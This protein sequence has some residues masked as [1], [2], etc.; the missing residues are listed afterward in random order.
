MKFKSK[1]TCLVSI[2]YNRSAHVSVLFDHIGNMF[3]YQQLSPRLWT[4]FKAFTVAMLT[5]Q[6]STEPIWFLTSYPEEIWCCDSGC[7]QTNKS[8]E[9][10]SETHC[11]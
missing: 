8:S 1:C 6:G 5:W 3:S 10:L 9:L 2:F 7:I 4:F 11:H